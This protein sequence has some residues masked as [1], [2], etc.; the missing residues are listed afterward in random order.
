MAIA[1]QDIMRGL[2]PNMFDKYSPEGKAEWIVAIAKWDRKSL[3]QHKSFRA[4]VLIQSNEDIGPYKSLYDRLWESYEKNRQ[5]VLSQELTTLGLEATSNMT[6]RD[7]KNAY[8]RQARKLHPDVGGSDDD[9]KA[10][11]SAY[12]TVLAITPA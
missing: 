11:H 9:F 6:K 4:F 10:L 7:V 12:R 2:P 5:H 1:E 3:R 8:R